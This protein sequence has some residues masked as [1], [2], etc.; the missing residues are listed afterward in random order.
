MT[1][2]GALPSNDL[3]WL[4]LQIGYQDSSLSI[5]HKDDKP[6]WK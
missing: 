2:T 4:K 3:Q 5:D 1:S 6:N